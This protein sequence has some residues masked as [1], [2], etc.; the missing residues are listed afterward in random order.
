MWEDQMEGTVR[1][2]M[3]KVDENLAKVVLWEESRLLAK[4]GSKYVF[5][6]GFSID[7]K[8]IRLWVR[9]SRNGK[10]IPGSFHVNDREHMAETLACMMSGDEVV[11]AEQH[12]RRFHAVP[13]TVIGMLE[14]IEYIRASLKSGKRSCKV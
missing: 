5:M 10:L 14:T 8:G 9:R 4:D 1:K 12:L 6:R 2:T 13:E 11:T 7:R 3:C